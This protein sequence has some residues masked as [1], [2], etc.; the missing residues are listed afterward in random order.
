MPRKN[1]QSS[2]DPE[3]ELRG[4]WSEKGLPAERQD[5]LIAEIK[6]KATVAFENDER[7]IQADLFGD[8][9]PCALKR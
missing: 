9:S 6:T 7:P 3:V 8:A 5:A 4:I 1:A 2:P